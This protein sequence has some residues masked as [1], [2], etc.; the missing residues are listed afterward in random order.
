MSRFKQMRAVDDEATLNLLQRSFDDFCRDASIGSRPR[1]LPLAH[2]AAIK[3]NPKRA[4]TAT[5]LKTITRR[6]GSGSR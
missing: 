5:A 1:D 6:A 4:S 3:T 2:M